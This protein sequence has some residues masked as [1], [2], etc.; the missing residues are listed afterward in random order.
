MRAAGLVLRDDEAAA[1]ELADFGLGRWDEFGLAIHVYVNTAR[2]CAKELVMLPGQCCPEHRHPPLDGDPGKEETFRVRQGEVFL[3]LPG[4]P[5]A[6]AQERALALLPADK[7]GVVTAFR[8]VHLRTGEQCTL[9]PD[10]RH[11]FVAGR[12]GAV[13]S[14]F[15]TRSRDEADVFTD[16]AIRR[17]A[18]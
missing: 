13:V 4:E 11:W 9:A 16:P 17:V 15:S 5:G 1:L 14:E 10:T 18:G 6:A 12:E 3:F 2:C 7:H 8:C